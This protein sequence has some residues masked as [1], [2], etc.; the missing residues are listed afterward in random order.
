M[1]GFASLYLVQ[2]SGRRAFGASGRV[3][4][5]VTALG[6]ASIGVYLGRF[7]GFNS[8]EPSCTRSAWPT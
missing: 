6:L 1:L 7:I 2:M 8:W 3:V 4:G 5:V